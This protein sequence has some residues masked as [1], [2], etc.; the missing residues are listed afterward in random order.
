MK[1]P[2]F[3]D[4]TLLKRGSHRS[5]SDGMCFMEA[6]A[7]ITGDEHSPYPACVGRIPRMIGIQL[8]DAIPA[9]QNR[10]RTEFLIPLA[11]LVVD[12]WCEYL[13][14]LDLR[15][16]IVYDDYRR[17]RSE[18]PSTVDNWLR[19]G[20]DALTQIADLTAQAPLED[21]FFGDITDPNNPDPPSEQVIL[22]NGGVFGPTPVSYRTP[23]YLGALA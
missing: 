7:W 1:E 2:T 23:D 19:V 15:H 13:S 5:R 18:L 3:P 17:R 8:N 9:R 14:A 11:P 10:K 12:T 20:E 22:P 4:G 6:I 16:Q 21:R